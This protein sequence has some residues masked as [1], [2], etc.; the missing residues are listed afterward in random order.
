MNMFVRFLLS[1]AIG[2]VAGWVN[3]QDGYDHRALFSPLFYPAGGNEYRAGNG[4]PG[5]KYWQNRADYQI[6]CTLDTA[7]HRLT[8]RVTIRYTNNSPQQLSVLWLQMD[9]NLYRE[10]SRGNVT[11][12]NSGRYG[13]K[14]GTKG[15]ETASVSFSVNGKTYKPEYSEWDTRM[16]VRPEQPVAANGGTAIINME[17][18][19][20]IPEYGTDRMGRME[21]KYGWI[22]EMAQWYPRM[23]VYD[24]VDGW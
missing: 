14:Q 6:T 23:C 1:L 12:Q 20:T 8:G 3:A 16:Q 5:P 22:Y 18:A 11:T 10:N 9:Q 19:F 24:D 17:Y 21:T 15:F 7:A 2:L 13:T 4:E